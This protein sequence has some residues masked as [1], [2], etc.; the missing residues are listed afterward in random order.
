MKKTVICLITA[1][2]LLCGCGGASKQEK[3]ASLAASAFDEGDYDA[4]Y[5]Y[6]NQIPEIESGFSNDDTE[7]VQKKFRE[8]DDKL[9]EKVK[10]AVNSA[11]TEEEVRDSIK[12]TTVVKLSS[13]GLRSE[14]DVLLQ[15][16][17]SMIGTGGN[18]FYA[19]K[20]AKKTYVI[21]IEVVSPEGPKI[22]SAQMVDDKEPAAP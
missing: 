19:E 5:E 2:A 9:A 14:N 15:E 4:A 7:Y 11:L 22:V 1:A 10:D 21:T 20:Y 17:K 6:I 16:V 13:K 12:G 3:L 18:K 8:K